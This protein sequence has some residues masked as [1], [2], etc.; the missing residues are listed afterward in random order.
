MPRNLWFRGAERVEK[1]DTLSQK[2]KHFFEGM[3]AAARTC[4]AR[5]LA[6]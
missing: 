5:T 1:L 4:F 6:A 3:Q 2:C